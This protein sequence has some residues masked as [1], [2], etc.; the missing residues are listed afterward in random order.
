MSDV[1]EKPCVACGSTDR[2]ADGTCGPCRRKRSAKYAAANPEKIRE[3]SAKYRATGKPNER[4][5]IWR[6][7]NPDIERA[8]RAKYYYE[9]KEK[10]RQRG[11]RY[12][13]ENLEKARARLA[14]YRAANKDKS[15]IYRQNRRANKANNG[16][17]LSP[18]LAQRLH[19]LQRG[20]CACCGQ[21]LK[22]DYHLDHILPLALGGTNTD[23]NIQLLLPICNRQKHSKHPVDFMQQRGLLL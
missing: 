15:S 23:S 14:R 2:Y 17:T 16:G 5:R 21:P 18:G 9:N 3:R 12:W 7:A 11:A 13:A 1:R 10:V 6:A 4:Q 20:K 19:K 22:N 8:Y